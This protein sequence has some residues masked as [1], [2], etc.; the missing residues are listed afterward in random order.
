[1]CTRVFDS[2]SAP[3]QMCIP[4][5]SNGFR[6]DVSVHLYE[7]NNINNINEKKIVTY[8]EKHYVCEVSTLLVYLV[9]KKHLLVFF[10][11]DLVTR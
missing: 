1:M 8:D 3:S 7:Y 2:V 4:L 10:S 11:F 9:A 6:I 5:H